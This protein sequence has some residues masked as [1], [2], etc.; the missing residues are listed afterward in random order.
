MT[1]PLA[2]GRV[3]SRLRDSSWFAFGATTTALV[4]L[5]SGG[6]VLLVQFGADESRPPQHAALP[7]APTQGLP[8]KVPA[9]V[10]VD[11]VVGTFHTPVAVAA[12]SLQ[13]H[14]SLSELLSPPTGPVKLPVAKPPVP[15][16]PGVVLV[17]GTPPIPIGPGPQPTPPTFH[18]PVLPMPGPL[19]I[20]LPIPL[21]L[22]LPLPLPTIP[23]PAPGVPGS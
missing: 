5:A 22:P 17:P 16:D 3:R 15:Q 13:G 9:S 6:T 11:R 19:P 1:E 12:F 20:T 21:P 2:T 7:V 8:P 4:L 14:Q 23:V 18:P 10:T